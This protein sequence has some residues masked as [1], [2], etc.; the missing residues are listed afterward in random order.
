MKFTL[1]AMST[2]SDEMA[3]TSTQQIN[4]MTLQPTLFILYKIMLKQNILSANIKLKN[5]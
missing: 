2:Y 4:A 3:G 1:S 5:T